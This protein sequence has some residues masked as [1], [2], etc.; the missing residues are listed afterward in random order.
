MENLSQKYQKAAPNGR[1]WK[2]LE[3]RSKSRSFKYRG[4]FSKPQ[5]RNGSCSALPVNNKGTREFESLD[6]HF[7]WTRPQQISQVQY[8]FAVGLRSPGVSI[9]GPW[10]TQKT[11]QIAAFWSKWFYFRTNHQLIKIFMAWML[12]RAAHRQSEIPEK[13]CGCSSKHFKGW[14]SR[15]PSQVTMAT[16]WR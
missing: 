12:K 9:L 3:S 14:T 4:I 11:W 16:R 7:Y 15:V 5:Q 8:W 1:G 2:I 13:S 10:N 6:S